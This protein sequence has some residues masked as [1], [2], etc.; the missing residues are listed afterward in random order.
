MRNVTKNVTLHSMNHISSEH[1]EMKVK[2][3]RLSTWM[4]SRGIT[5]MTTEEIAELLD[6]PRAQV[7]TRLA[8]QRERGAIVSPARGLWVP[9]PPDRAAWGAPE[10]GAYIDDMMHY[11]DCA[12]YVGWLSAASLYGAGHQAVQEF[13]V[14]TARD[15]RD[16]TVGRSTLRFMTRSRIEAVPVTKMPVSSS[17]ARVSTV[18]ATMLDVVGDLD[19]SGGIDNAVTVVT[20][21]AWENE[22]FLP[23][24]LTASR[25][26]SAAAV[27]RLGW[28]LE[29]VAGIDGL[30]ELVRLVEAESEFPS[31]L[32]PTSLKAGN[33]DKRWNLILNK[34]VDPDV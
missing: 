16:R 24:V 29:N 13:Q 1:N 26:H 22:D 3:S 20:E 9:V 8:V 34:E 28:I 30:D 15:V 5:S 10:P 4:L 31:L 33:L 23:D 12:Y 25:V 17:L 27:R 32:S 19:I 7:R 11:L 21:L 14:A 18:G 6:I 2:A